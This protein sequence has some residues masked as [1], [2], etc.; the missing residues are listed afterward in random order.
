VLVALRAARS[1]FG[2][3]DVGWI[4]A[5]GMRI[6]ETHAVPRVN[7]YSFVAPDHPWIMHE[8]GFGVLYALGYGAFGLRF[9]AML[10]AVATMAT[11]AIVVDRAFRALSPAVAAVLC[12]ALFVVAFDRMTSARPVGVVT[13][14]A[15]TMVVL[16]SRRTVL[17]RALAVLVQ[18]LW[19]NV[20]GSFPLGLVILAA[21]GA[22]PAVLGAAVLST[23]LNP[24]GPRLWAH[25]LRYAVGTDATIAIIRERVLEFAPVWRSG[26]HVVVTPFEIAGLVVLAAAAAHRRSLLVGGL[27]LLGLLQARNVTMALVVGTLVLLE[28]KTVRERWI[29]PVA[30][31]TMALACMLARGAID[32]A[33]GG[34]AFV[35]LVERLPDRARVFVPFRASGLLLLTAAQRGV[36]TFFDARN[37]CYPPDIARIGLRLKDGELPEGRLA[38]AL[39]PS[40]WAIV[41]S[42]AYVRATPGD[43]RFAQLAVLEPALTSYRVVA[44]EGGWLLL[45]APE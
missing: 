28:P 21:R 1:P 26:Y 4:T 9:F 15:A 24:Y 37:D 43:A 34:T 39:R 6:W 14:L 38:A 2:D 10:A 32:D 36:T 3:V 41:P 12:A 16:T 22:R 44:R 40:E 23:F 33:I 19:T 18:L 7:G 11:G 8:W 30:V 25:V 42:A 35:S 29:A 17:S 20:H 5:A 27:V 13:L 31:A 45:R